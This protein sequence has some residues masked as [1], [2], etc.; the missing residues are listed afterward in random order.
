M[1]ADPAVLVGTDGSEGAQAAVRWA[2]VEAVRRD[3]DLIILH[4]HDESWA[5][6]PRD[7][8]R[9]ARFAPAAV[10]DL[11]GNEAEAVVSAARAAAQAIAPRLAV[12]TEVVA[13]DPVQALLS[14]APEVGVIVVGHRGRDGFTSLMLGS[15]S[16]RV[17][18]HSACPTVVVRGR[19]MA[20]GGPVVVGVDGSADSDHVLE[21][22]FTA[23]AAR[24]APL[25]AIL[26][27]PMLLPAVG[28]GAPSPIPVELEQLQSDAEQ[29]LEQSLAPWRAKFP[30]VTVQTRVT[31]GGAARQLVGA[32]HSA[33]LVVVGSHGSGV[34]TGVLL[35]SVSL[36]V[37][38]HADCPVLVARAVTSDRTASRPPLST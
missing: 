9:Q 7:R 26:A 36:Q 15:V 27:Y 14:R 2:A 32:S 19:D 31:G 20:I 8:G 4:A 35:G 13:G 25:L 37:L 18:T 17:A 5:R 21:A 38:H 12:H 33:Q 34:V 30:E 23:A 24:R 28:F 3:T 10:I 22:A 6:L 29:E 11:T 16:Q 1:S